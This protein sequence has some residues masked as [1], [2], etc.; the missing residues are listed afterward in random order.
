M[1]EFLVDHLHNLIPDYS[2]FGDKHS[3][4]CKVKIGAVKSHQFQAA[5]A[6]VVE[7][8]IRLK[9]L[10]YF[11]KR[12]PK[13]LCGLEQYGIFLNC[14]GSFQFFVIDDRIPYKESKSKK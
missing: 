8:K 14:Q 2:I 12:G 5:L 10:I 9:R 4:P 7:D 1:S 3:V 13:V 11:D 6:A